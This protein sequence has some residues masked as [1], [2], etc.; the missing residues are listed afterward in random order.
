MCLELEIFP[1][2][3]LDSFTIAVCVRLNAF[4]R[5]HS[6]SSCLHG[7]AAGLKFLF[8]DLNFEHFLHYCAPHY[9]SSIECLFYSVSDNQL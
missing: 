2:W 9:W 7:A 8:T 1:S 6:K 4:D 3:L 5:E